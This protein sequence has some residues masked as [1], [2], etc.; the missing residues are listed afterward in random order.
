ME[1]SESAEH[2]PRRH[3][4]RSLLTRTTSAPASILSLTTTAPIHINNPRCA[5]CRPPHRAALTPFRAAMASLMPNRAESFNTRTRG[6]SHIDFK[7]ATTGVAA[8]AMRNELSHL[9]STISD[10]QEK[11][12]RPPRAAYAS[13]LTSARRTLT[14]RCNPSSS[15]SPATSPSAPRARICA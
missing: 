13:R 7:T 1:Q 11:K 3:K 4:T 6:T 15:S 5:P 2:L 8:K 14:W 12:V 10:P 9:V